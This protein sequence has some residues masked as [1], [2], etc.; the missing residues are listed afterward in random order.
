VTKF[1]QTTE[2][3]YNILRKKEFQLSAAVAKAAVHFNQQFSTAIY[4]RIP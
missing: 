2:F 4:V 3:N 1:I